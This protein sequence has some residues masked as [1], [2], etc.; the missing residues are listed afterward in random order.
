MVSL[1][2]EG[3]MFNRTGTLTTTMII[4]KFDYS[5][6]EVAVRSRWTFT[7]VDIWTFN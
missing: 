3:R 7:Y 6:S 2:I 4:I 5:V 1:I